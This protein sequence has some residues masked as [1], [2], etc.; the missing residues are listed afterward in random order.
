MPHFRF[1]RTASEQT[2]E[3]LR[4]ESTSWSVRGKVVTDG[5]TERDFWGKERLDL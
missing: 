5:V 4:F 3:C 1:T 2:L